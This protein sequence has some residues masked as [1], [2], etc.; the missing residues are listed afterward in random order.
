MGAVPAASELDNGRQT[1]DARAGVDLAGT[2]QRVVPVARLPEL[3]NTSRAQAQQLVQEGLLA[4][5]QPDP[6]QRQGR[7]GCA[8]DYWEVDRFL[9]ELA[10]NTVPVADVPAGIP[11]AAERARCPT[12]EIVRLILA[13]RLKRV[14]RLDWAK[15][16]A[17]ILVDVLEVRSILP[18]DE[19]GMLLSIA[20]QR[21]MI[22]AEG[23]EAITDG[24]AGPPLLRTIGDPP[25]AGSAS[26]PRVSNEDLAAFARR[27]VS[28]RRLGALHRM[29]LR[30]VRSRL[31][32]AGV[33]PILAG[34]RNNFRIFRRMDIPPDCFA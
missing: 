6:D 11:Q 10:R 4:T 3:L 1:V 30:K 28:E 21:L 8:V 23:G 7:Q 16:Y 13:G 27:Y 12:T 31:D 20:L 32:R 19:T 14:A 5:L 34:E 22:D 15:G 18:R 29:G 33:V 17:S 9:A 26:V 2:L 24:K 25:S